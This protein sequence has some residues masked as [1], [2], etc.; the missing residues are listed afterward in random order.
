MSSANQQWA[1]GI[2]WTGS[3]K[4]WCGLALIQPDGRVVVRHELTWKGASPE[5][6]AL[7]IKAK[8]ARE[9]IAALLYLA[10]NPEMF[11]KGNESGPSTS[12]SFIIAGLPMRCGSKDRI[13]GFAT[14]RA[15]MHPRPLPWLFFH[16]E[17]KH[18]LRTL[19]TLI[20]DEAEPDDIAATTDAYPAEGLMQ[21]VMARPTP[22]TETP[23]KPPLDP[24]S[25]AYLW[26]E[27]RQG[28]I[29]E[30]RYVGWNRHR[31]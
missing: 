9:K 17:C 19:P 26:N 11:P 22:W 14:V 31:L 6:A 10:G 18:L 15:W 28:V 25:G 29:G 30:T 13:N 23:K 1:G 24:L 4:A 3:A 12:E 16:R 7:D 20:A 8:M 2:R 27:L 21:L 5:Q